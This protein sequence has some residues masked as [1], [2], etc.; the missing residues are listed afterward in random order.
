MRAADLLI[1]GFEGAELT[2]A[3]R[4]IL[5][6]LKPGGVILFQR[7]IA[8]GEQLHALVADLRALCG[9]TVLYVDAEGG[10]VDR[11]RNVVGPAPT[12][13][14][15][16]EARPAV[17]R[18]AGRWIGLALRH[19]GFDVDFAPVVDLDRGELDNALD[20][21][22]LGATPRAVA[23]RG[24]A[25]LDGLQSAGVAGCLKHFP[26]LGA[27]RMDTHRAGAPIDLS[28]DGLTLDL[29]PFRSLEERAGMIM[30]SHAS[31]AAFDAA[32]PATLSPE[33]STVLLRRTSASAGPG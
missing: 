23:A 30:A 21:R 29:V 17:A 22:Y 10:R 20:G 26:G 5:R 33:I 13:S 2:V 7:N 18:Q 16:A 25:F 28:V 12:A 32:R 11:L 6:R 4:K 3:E 27:A 1:V 15:L 9:E 31:Y 8:S 14:A 24:R 19:F